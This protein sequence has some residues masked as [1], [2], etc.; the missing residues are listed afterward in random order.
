M[1]EIALNLNAS[2]EAIA[3]TKENFVFDCLSLFYVLDD[4]YAEN[5]LNAGVNACNVTFGAETEWPAMI[6]SIESGLEKIEKS[7][8]L[9]LATTSAEIEKANSKGQLAII[10]GT[11]GS[12]MVDRKL[13]RISIMH[14]LG[15]RYF[16]LAYTAATLLADGCGETRDAGITFLGKEAIK[17]VNDLPLI[18]DLS[19]CGH[20]TR[21]E[22]TDLARAPV[23]THS[24][25]YGLNAN[26]RNTKDDTAKAI[27]AKNGVVGICGL[28]KTVNPGTATI[29]HMLDHCDYYRDLIGFEHIG[30]GLD[31]TEAYKISGEIFPES[32]R[33]R[34]YRPDIFGTVDEFFTQSYP[35][36][37]TT[38]LE[39][40]NFTQGLIDRGYEEHE[41]AAILG[42][43][44]LRNFKNYVG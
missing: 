6:A 1:T 27:A 12:L 31:L 44:W 2:A 26:D 21:L 9:S 24:N 34:T 41:V 14:R 8:L 22:A 18:L 3:F 19:H 39:L 33:W 36:G 38:I 10:M 28:P 32:R 43:N 42:N 37:L 17:I 5:C 7:H 13:E 4:S 25:A 23:C 40:P 16:G 20:N 35:I 30:I 29:E 15:M 11:Q